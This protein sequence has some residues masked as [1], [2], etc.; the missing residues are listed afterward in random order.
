MYLCMYACMYICMYVCISWYVIHMLN[1]HACA[2]AQ[3]DTVRI[4]SVDCMLT[5]N[6]AHQ[7]TD[8]RAFWG[9]SRSSLVPRP[10]KAKADLE[11]TRKRRGRGSSKQK[12]YLLVVTRLLICDPCQW[13]AVKHWLKACVMPATLDSRVKALRSTLHWQTTNTI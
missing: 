4:V 7:T 5:L 13:C 6:V 11:E 2:C 8:A 3:I 12:Q 10:R 1:T 9:S